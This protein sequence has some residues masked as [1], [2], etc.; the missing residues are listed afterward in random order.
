M[1]IRVWMDSDS[2]SGR[3]G[4]SEDGEGSKMEEDHYESELESEDDNGEFIR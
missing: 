4:E 3:E 1:L 2:Q